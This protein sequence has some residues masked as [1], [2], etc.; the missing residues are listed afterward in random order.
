MFCI[1]NFVNSQILCPC[2][3]AWQQ[4]NE[5]LLLAASAMQD[6]RLCKSQRRWIPSISAVLLNA[7]TSGWCRQLA[8]ARLIVM[9]DLMWSYVVL[10]LQVLGP[11]L[12]V[13]LTDVYWAVMSMGH[14]AFTTLVS[15]ACRTKRKS[16]E[17]Q[18][19]KSYWTRWAVSVLSLKD[20]DEL[21]TWKSTN[22]L[23]SLRADF[24]W[25]VQI[26]EKDDRSSCESQRN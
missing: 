12:P 15:H 7:G 26:H 8:V 13:P 16:L 20:G 4:I 17:Q 18:L 5:L 10:S 2:L 3:L 1:G 21:L 22:Y 6:S 14:V 9:L 23:E 24:S 19:T 11:R 25:R